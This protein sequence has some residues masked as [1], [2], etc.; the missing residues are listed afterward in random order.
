MNISDQPRVVHTGQVLIDLTL[1][2]AQ[3]PEPG[4]DVFAANTGMHVG[5]GYNVL[6]AVRQMGVAAEYAGCLGSGPLSDIAR[7]ALANV[8]VCH[9]GPSVESEL[10]YCVALTDDSSERTFI[11]TRGAET[12]DPISAFDNLR[13]G[14]EDVL[15]VCGYS[16]VHEKNRTAIER[17]LLRLAGSAEE[18]RPIV[19]F[20]AS[21]VIE[22]IPLTTLAKLSDLKPIWSV[23]EREA[24]ILA[25]RFNLQAGAPEDFCRLFAARQGSPVVVRIGAGGAYFSLGGRAIHIPTI[26]VDPVDTNGAGDAHSGVLC[27]LLVESQ[28]LENALLAANIAGALSTTQ[29][30]P[31]TC[32]SR[33]QIQAN[34]PEVS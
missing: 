9:T 10:G 16:L 18:D 17:L 24:E 8:D 27:A 2:L 22:N 34:L 29:R 23:N 19:V 5:G 14:G 31:A 30:G 28:G 33:E 11:S 15:Y 12:E 20:D 26:Q 4:G 25:R 3:L 6:Y 32:P 21:P 13:V 1:S 7:Q